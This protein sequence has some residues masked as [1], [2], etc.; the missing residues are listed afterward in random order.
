MTEDEAMA[1]SVQALEY[2]LENDGDHL[3]KEAFEE[4]EQAYRV[5]VVE[6]ARSAYLSRNP[7]STG[8]VVPV[9]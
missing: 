6:K 8:M 7:A 5:L 4:Y 9:T 2:V 3:E 1:L